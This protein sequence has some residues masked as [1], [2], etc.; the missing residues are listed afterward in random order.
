MNPD[1]K[2]TPKR[3]S[4]VAF[5]IEIIMCTFLIEELPFEENYC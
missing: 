5:F 2:L 4:T 3:V 1:E